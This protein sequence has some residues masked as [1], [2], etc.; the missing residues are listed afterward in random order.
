MNAAF[1]T[2]QDERVF[3]LDVRIIKELNYMFD[4]KMMIRYCYNILSEFLF[5]EVSVR[6]NSKV[7]YEFIQDYISPFFRTVIK[8]IVLMGWSPY[9]L[10]KMKDPRTNDN[11]IVPQTVSLL[12][13]K[14]YMIVNFRNNDF[15]FKFIDLNGNERKDIKVLMWSD[16]EELAVN[17]LC[18]SITR[19]LLIDFRFSQ[20]IKRFNLQSE[21]VRSRPPIFLKDDNKGSSSKQ[22]SV[23][24]TESMDGKPV[25]VARIKERTTPRNSIDQLKEAS[26]DLTSNIEYHI[27][28][29]KEMSYRN[30][31]DYFN[32]GIH[33]Q[34]QPWNNLFI[35]P[36]N[37]S[38]AAV[39]HLPESRMD[40][41]VTEKY[42]NS[43]VYQSF[44]IP[45]ALVGQMHNLSS[46]LRSSTRDTSRLKSDVNV[47]DLISFEGT[48]QR[49]ISFFRDS[50][51][52]I[53]EDIFKTK[54][55]K[56]DIEFKLPK[57]YNEF[58]STTYDD[59][60][61]S[62]LDKENEQSALHEKLSIETEDQQQK[63]PPKKRKRADDDKTSKTNTND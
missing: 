26:T 50:F 59:I 57:L 55:F 58:L 2:T 27:H 52:L 22:L 5:N 14:V 36:P 23:N 18:Y 39:P 38:L 9:I 25:A 15:K 12:F 28:Q 56:H 20:N 30:N 4:T 13:L 41:T 16:Y 29:M 46:A 61:R 43:A 3:E 31:A 6:N 42:F 54:I 32:V 24:H 35:C 34:P 10:K 44:G 17:G 48:L 60:V 1:Q 40:P 62:K 63:P 33:F 8:N 37:T 49:F 21:S 51:V 19:G 45:E 47:M 53:Y 11:I 7:L